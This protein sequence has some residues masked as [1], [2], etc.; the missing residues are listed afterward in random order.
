MATEKRLIDANTCPCLNCDTKDYDCYTGYCEEFTRWR[1]SPVDAVEVVHG[2]WIEKQEAIPWCEDDAEV[3]TV[4]SVCE[5]YSPGESNY[6]PNCGA[7]MDG[8]G[9]G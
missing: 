5:S 2:R 3:Y 9:N 8:D 4:C 7:K 6:C 1:L